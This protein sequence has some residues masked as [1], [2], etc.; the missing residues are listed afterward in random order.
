MKP[1]KL[2]MLLA[3]LLPLAACSLVGQSESSCPGKPNGYVCKGPREVYE[4]TNSKSSLFDGT[5]EGADGEK[6][7]ANVPTDTQG[8]GAMVKKPSG[9]PINTENPYG[10]NYS[11]P[12]P[13]AIR[14]DPRVLR[15][16]ISPYED[17]AGSLNMPGYAYVE[18]EPRRWLVGADANN[19]PARIV[20]LVVTQDAQQNL[21]TKEAKARTVDPLGVKHTLPIPGQPD[22][23]AGA[24]YK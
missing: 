4:I 20:P 7:S 16:L 6:K 8:L 22:V 5:Q 17:S 14:A 2:L 13:L 19:R 18:I 3:G 12:E 1:T 21:S 10:Q 9:T 15:I 11:A 24:L 23:P